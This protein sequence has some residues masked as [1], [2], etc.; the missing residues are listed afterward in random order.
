MQEG[1]Y[2]DQE[3]LHY[4]ILF[5]QLFLEMVKLI[6]E[7]DMLGLNFRHLSSSKEFLNKVQS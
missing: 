1:F 4:Q 2:Q 6:K 7:N 3:Y 5:E